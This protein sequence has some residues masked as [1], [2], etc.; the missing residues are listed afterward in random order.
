MRLAF[1]D[2][3]VAPVE[4]EPEIA[5]YVQMGLEEAPEDPDEDAEEL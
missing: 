5:G 2:E 4:E 3:L 1:F